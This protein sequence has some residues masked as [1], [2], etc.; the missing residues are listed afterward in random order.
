MFRIVSSLVFNRINNVFH[1]IYN[2]CFLYYEKLSFKLYSVCTMFP[3][4]RHSRL[5]RHRYT[6]SSGTTWADLI[7]V[8]IWRQYQLI[9]WQWRPADLHVWVPR[10]VLVIYQLHDLVT[11]KTCRPSLMSAPCRVLKGVSHFNNYS[12]L[13]SIIE[14]AK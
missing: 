3:L 5:G 2:L 4:S 11:M 10:A 14:W 1:T 7:T 9:S 12:P 13:I 6:G 8:K